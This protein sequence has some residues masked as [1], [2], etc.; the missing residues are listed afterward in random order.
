MLPNGILATTAVPQK[1]VPRLADDEEVVA[2]PLQGWLY[3][4][5][6]FSLSDIFNHCSIQ[7][8][9]R[10]FEAFGKSLPT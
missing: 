2:M 3:C 10:F 6:L 4:A 9:L 5:N 1:G 8:L 7:L